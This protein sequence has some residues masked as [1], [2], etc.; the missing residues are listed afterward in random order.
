MRNEDS[1]ISDLFNLSSFQWNAELAKEFNFDLGSLVHAINDYNY[2]IPSEKTIHN[3]GRLN[4]QETLK[5][6]VVVNLMKHG[7]GL[8]EAPLITDPSQIS[9][10]IATMR[11]SVNG[12]IADYGKGFRSFLIFGVDFTEV[13]LSGVIIDGCVFSNCTFNQCFMTS[14]LV[15]GSKFIECSFEKCDFSNSNWS[16]VGLFGINF[17]DCNLEGSNIFDCVQH[18]T[19]YYGC[20]LDGATIVAGSLHRVD[21]ES[22][23]MKKANLLNVIFSAM[24]LINS[25]LR[26]SQIVNNRFIGAKFEMLHLDTAVQYSNSF[27]GCTTSSEVLDFFSEGE[28][29]DEDQGEQESEGPLDELT[30][31]SFDEIMGDDDDDEH[32]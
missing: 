26:G 4:K 24:T 7:E 32:E 30:D 17:I 2:N 27:V 11:R 1:F 6:P 8:E 20:E 15:S 10:L 21:I 29:E 13:E 12:V 25:N 3:S 31:R 14:A 5:Q 18:A 23:S 28:Y 19:S 9:K 22:C 16:K